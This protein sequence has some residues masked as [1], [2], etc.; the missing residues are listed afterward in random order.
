M[1]K[2][3]CKAFETSFKDGWKMAKK[4]SSGGF[5]VAPTYDCRIAH[6]NKEVAKLLAEGFS[7]D[8]N[9]GRLALNILLEIYQKS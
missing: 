2:I 5:F 8:E 4:I 1:K 9:C 7:L 3:I 6:S